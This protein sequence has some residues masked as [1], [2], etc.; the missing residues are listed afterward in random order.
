VRVPCNHRGFGHLLGVGVD[1]IPVHPLAGIA[2]DRFCRPVLFEKR[3]AVCDLVYQIG[4]ASVQD[5]EHVPVPLEYRN[6]VLFLIALVQQSHTL[7]VGVVGYALGRGDRI[8]VAVV[9][10]R[11]IDPLFEPVDHHFADDRLLT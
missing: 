9:I 6:P 3:V 1:K 5:D 4:P 7:S 10:N 2:T 11:A 8:L